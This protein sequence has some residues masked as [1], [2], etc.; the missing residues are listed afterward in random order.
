MEIL[1]R[2]NWVDVLV[3][4]IVF[5]VSYVAFQDGLS[6]EIF[7]LV[8]AIGTAVLTL[9]YYHK[10]AL[11]ISQN[12]VSIPV[13]IMDFLVFIL[14][15]IVIGIIFKL[16]RVVVDKLIKVT[17][18]PLVEKLGGLFFGVMRASVV[19]SVVLIILALMP[20]PYLQ[21]SIRDRSLTGMHFL[22]VAP[23][24][25]GKVSAFLPTLTVEGTSADNEGMVRELAADKS[26]AQKK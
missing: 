13:K 14:L 24:I 15:I 19:A 17:W 20:I 1:S 18:H 10:I 23:N 11:L 16:I 8:G 7:P 4:I 3:I 5:R 25:Y 21:Y 12:L 2:F 9:H 6:H 22:R 26:I